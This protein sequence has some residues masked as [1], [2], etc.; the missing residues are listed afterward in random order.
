MHIRRLTPKDALPF[1]ALRLAALKEA[2]SAFASSYEEEKDF[3][4]A[5]VE[6]RL[7]VRED[8]G[9]FGAFLNDELLGMA[10]LG[11]LE[12]KKVHHKALI[13]SVYV[14]PTARSRGIGRA[15]VEAALALARSVPGIRQVN[16]SVTAGNA[17]A[18]RLYESLGFRRYGLEPAALLVAGELHDELHLTLP[19]AAD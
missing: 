14:A 1:Q 3:S 13:W 5:L 9:A 2:P 11:R 16:V 4:L 8:R 18:V 7:A 12:Q 17:A 19:V 10:V 6:G 15:L